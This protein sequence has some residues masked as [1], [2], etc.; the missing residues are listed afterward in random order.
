MTKGHS[1]NCPTINNVRHG[2]QQILDCDWLH[3]HNL[4]SAE[5]PIVLHYS[6]TDSAGS[7]QLEVISLFLPFAPIL[8]HSPLPF[9]PPPTPSEH[10]PSSHSPLSSPINHFISLS[11]SSFVCYLLIL[12]DLRFVHTHT[13]SLS[14]YYFKVFPYTT[15]TSHY[16]SISPDR[17]T[18][19]C[20][21]MN[22]VDQLQLSK[23]VSSLIRTLNLLMD[24]LLL[25]WWLAR[26]WRWFE[27][28][29][30]ESF[31]AESALLTL[32]TVH[33]LK[34]QTK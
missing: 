5:W 9:P 34:N 29:R 3:R 4:L 20:T 8:P 13:L 28:W 16:Y 12:Y 17:E 11:L 1:Q 31:F 15:S 2:F 18:S 27:P 33:T 26:W 19:H 10:S 24:L 25:I 21:S 30:W 14:T 6:Q 23:A 7:N 32:S 22:R